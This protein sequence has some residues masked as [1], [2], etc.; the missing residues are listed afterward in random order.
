MRE[1]F[2]RGGAVAALGAML[3]GGNREDGSAQA[4]IE[5]AEGMA[6]SGFVGRVF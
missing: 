4:I 6:W 5:F 3:G 2:A 1:A